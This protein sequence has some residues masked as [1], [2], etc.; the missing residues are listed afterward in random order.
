V[1]IVKAAERSRI[2]PLTKGIVAAWV[3]AVLFLSGLQLYATR[4]N[5]DGLGASSDGVRALPR[6]K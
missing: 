1:A 6:L 3:P 4:P 5:S 2:H